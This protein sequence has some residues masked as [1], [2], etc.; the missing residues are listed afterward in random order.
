M[1]C[2]TMKVEPDPRGRAHPIYFF[3][4]TQAG[5]SK[6]V[7]GLC[8][9]CDYDVNESPMLG[10]N[11]VQF[12]RPLMVG[13]AYLVRGEIVSLVRK[14]SRKLGVI[15]VLEYRLRLLLPDGQ[16]VLETTNNWILPRK[17]LA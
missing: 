14:S 7:A 5:M 6:T 2:A 1:L 3:I 13:Q 17:S 12:Q 11:Q 16:P 8:S 15:D 4:A 10:S 9:A